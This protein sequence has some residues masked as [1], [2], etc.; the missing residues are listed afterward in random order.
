MILDSIYDHWGVSDGFATSQTP[1]PVIPDHFEAFQTIFF[2]N[3][4]FDL[5]NAI[6]ANMS[7]EKLQILQI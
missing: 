1:F 6:F 7:F 4:I 3:R 2:Q 5:E